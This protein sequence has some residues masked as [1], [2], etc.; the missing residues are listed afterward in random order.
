MPVDATCY[1]LPAGADPE[2]VVS[3]LAERLSI[4]AD[5][6]RVLDRTFVDTFDGRLHAEGVVLDRATPVPAA[7]AAVIED[8]ALLPVA[9]VRSTIAPLRVLNGDEK[10]VVRLEV[11]RPELVVRGQPRRPLRARVHVRPVRGY[12]RAAERARAVL[13][14]D[15]ALAAGAASLVDEAV[16]AAGG[17][18]AG[19]SSKVEVPLRP[20]ERTDV[21]VIALLARLAEV[22]DLN[23]PGTL[24]DIDPEFLHDLRVALRRSRSLLRE[25]KGVLPPAERDRFREELRWLQQVTGPVRDLDVHLADIESYVAVLPVDFAADLAP[26][27]ATL[28]RRRV[29]ELRAMRRVLRSPRRAQ[30]RDDWVAFL[31]AVPAIPDGEDRPNASQPVGQVARE[32]IAKVYGQMLEMGSAIDAGSPGQALHDLRKRGKELRYLLELFGS[33]LPP[34]PTKP[35]V[36]ALKALQD[37][38]GRF[39]DREVQADALRDLGP[40]LARAERGP[41]AL[42]AMGLIVDRLN[43]EQVAARAEFADRF[44]AFS[45]R[46]T[47][48]K[49]AEVV[50]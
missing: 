1:V 39:Q 40:D 24:D 50:G 17:D 18:P 34:A 30:L 33:L 7:L 12:D 13:S 9:R 23:L 37:T 25:M 38:L 8:R 35:L 26:L 15:L 48:R 6:P 28:E 29:R 47:R 49:V 41:H 3:Q 22:M 20:D 4:A 10:T 36:S 32:R 46:G 45:S 31:G 27:R 14:D 19:T 21:A 42:M 11:E 16:V 2:R 5:Q 44:A 43:A